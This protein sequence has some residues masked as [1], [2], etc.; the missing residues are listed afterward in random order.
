M[1][2][3]LTT[4]AHHP[5]PLQVSSPLSCYAP[6]DH[7]RGQTH[8]S[9]AT[10]E[11]FLAVIPHFLAKIP[12]CALNPYHCCPVSVCLLVRVCVKERETDKRNALYPTIVHCID[13]LFKASYILFELWL[14]KSHFFMCPFLQTADGESD[15]SDWARGFWWHEGAGATVSNTY[16]FL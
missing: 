2:L 11:T 8:T 9:W 12:H 6:S 7:T 14:W 5:L 15:Y 4:H 3:T 1:K 13:F 10:L 16:G